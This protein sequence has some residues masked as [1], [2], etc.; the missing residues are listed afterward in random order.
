MKDTKAFYK[1]K[2][3]QKARDSKVIL[4][5]SRVVAAN[6]ITQHV[7]SG[8]M[9]CQAKPYP[10][11]HLGSLN[12]FGRSGHLKILHIGRQTQDRCIFHV[13]QLLHFE[14]MWIERSNLSCYHGCTGRTENPPVTQLVLLPVQ[15]YSPDLAKFPT[16][17]FQELGLSLNFKSQWNCSDSKKRL[18][19]STWLHNPNNTQSQSL[20]FLSSS[21]ENCI[22]FTYIDLNVY[23]SHIFLNFSVDV[24]QA[25]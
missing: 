22:C 3:W 19:L 9:C 24:L 13:C 2:A 1:Q 18:R 17:F 12:S 8:H 20:L 23:Q 16:G 11:K 14:L 5:S 15:I 7:A 10:N 4:W 25:L 21:L 6:K